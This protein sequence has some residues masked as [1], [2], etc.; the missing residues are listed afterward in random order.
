MGMDDGAYVCQIKRHDLEGL[1]CNAITFVSRKAMSQTEAYRDAV[2]T[3]MEEMGK[4]Y[5]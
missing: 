5:D 4:D 1:S 2:F 3:V